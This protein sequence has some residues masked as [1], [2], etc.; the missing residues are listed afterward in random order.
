MPLREMFDAGITVSGSSDAPVT[1]PSPIC[2]M[3]Y[4]MNH[5]NEEQSLDAYQALEMFTINGAKAVRE[6]TYKG[7]LEKGKLADFVILD[8][9]PLK[10]PKN[11]IKNIKVEQVFKNGVRIV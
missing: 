9:N 2:G 1:M 8:K 11:E 5:P 10:L 3:Y 6:E 7:S 4:A